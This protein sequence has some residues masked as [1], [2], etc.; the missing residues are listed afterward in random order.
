MYLPVSVW[1]VASDDLSFTSV[2]IDRNYSLALPQWKCLC[3]RGSRDQP[4]PGSFFQRP[5]KAEKRDPGNEVT[6]KTG[7]KSKK[8]KIEGVESGDSLLI[9]GRPK[10][11]NVFDHTETVTTQARN[12]LLAQ[13]R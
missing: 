2:E 11:V 8:K 9:I 6:K 13:I 7:T 10:C 5:R 3:H 12:T 1:H 4:Q